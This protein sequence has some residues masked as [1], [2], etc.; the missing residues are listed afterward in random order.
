MEQRGHSW[1]CSFK[2]NQY[3]RHWKGNQAWGNCK[4]RLREDQ[5]TEGQV[6]SRGF[7]QNEVAFLLK[8]VGSWGKA[9]KEIIYSQFP[10]SHVSCVF[11]S[12][13]K[14]SRGKRAGRGEKAVAQQPVMWWGSSEK[15]WWR[16]GCSRAVPCHLHVNFTLGWGTRW[17]RTMG[18]L[19]FSLRGGDKCWSQHSELGTGWLHSIVLRGQGWVGAEPSPDWGAVMIKITEMTQAVLGRWLPLLGLCFLTCVMSLH[20]QLWVLNETMHL[21]IHLFIQPFFFFG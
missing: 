6:P 19:S 15:V 17:R 3:S 5:T 9:S 8:N 4:D 16:E 20:L 18:L 1:W 7:W 13:Q 12:A 10:R 14:K 21:F 11:E 2:I